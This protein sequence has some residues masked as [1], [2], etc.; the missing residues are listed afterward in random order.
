M[1]GDASYCFWPKPDM[2]HALNLSVES[3]R[4][5]FP[6]DTKDDGPFIL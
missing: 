1:V 6:N 5:V 3:F 4:L 2:L